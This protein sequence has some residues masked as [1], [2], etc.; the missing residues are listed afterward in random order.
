MRPT[1]LAPPIGIL[2]LAGSLRRVYSRVRANAVARKA[3]FRS[4]RCTFYP[5]GQ[6]PSNPHVCSLMRRYVDVSEDLVL[7]LTTQQFGG[8]VGQLR[9]GSTGKVVGCFSVGPW[10]SWER[11]PVAPGRLSVPF[12]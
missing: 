7:T 12:R 4:R 8:T 10:R 6:S 2:R 9:P 5:S 11:V 3:I 1:N